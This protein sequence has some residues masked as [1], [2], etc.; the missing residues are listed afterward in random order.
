M[1]DGL[2]KKPNQN[3]RAGRHVNPHKQLPSKATLN[4]SSNDS[5]TA[6]L[7]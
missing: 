2:G 1:G 7:K 6:K 4:Y 3:K 5:E